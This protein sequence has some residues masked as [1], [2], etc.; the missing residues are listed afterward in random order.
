MLAKQWESTETVL[1]DAAEHLGG[2]T[3]A[4]FEE[5]LGHNELGLALDCLV[6]EGD[7]R[8]GSA[9]YWRLLIQAAELMG[10]H[11]LKNE[12]RRRVGEAEGGEGGNAVTRT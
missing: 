2:D 3:I 6:S 9:A 1:R 10:V 12:L 8:G 11:E 5:Y 4:D 7:L